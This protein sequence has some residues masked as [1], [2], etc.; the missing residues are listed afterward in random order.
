MYQGKVLINVL[1]WAGLVINGLVAFIL[2]LILIF[3]VIERINIDTNRRKQ[4]LILEK[5]GILHV[6]KGI[7]ESCNQVFIHACIY[8]YIHECVYVCM[9]VYVCI[10]MCIYIYL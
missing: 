5:L 8:V 4:I 1:N 7:E 3:K 2:P 10:Y 6:F 9:Y